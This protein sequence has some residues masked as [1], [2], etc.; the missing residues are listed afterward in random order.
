MPHNGFGLAA[1]GDF[2]ARNC[3]LALNL[4]KST[5]FSFYA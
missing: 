4:F 5:N 3:Q 1:G 2:E